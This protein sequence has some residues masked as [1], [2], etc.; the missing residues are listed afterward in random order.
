MRTFFAPLVQLLLLANGAQAAQVSCDDQLRSRFVAADEALA[1][2]SKAKSGPLLSTK[3]GENFLA[4]SQ[5]NQTGLSSETKPGN[6]RRLIIQ[7]LNGFTGAV[8]KELTLSGPDHVIRDVEVVDSDQGRLVLA[9]ETGNFS[10]ME[11]YTRV[12]VYKFKEK[13]L[14][15]IAL[16]PELI[17][18]VSRKNLLDAQDGVLKVYFARGMNEGSLIG[19]GKF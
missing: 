19:E 12:H 5:S 15:I 17:G 7:P 13:S 1:E 11:A 4:L 18:T 10:G 14:E 16:P 3:S 2:I 6:Y 8:E 9:W